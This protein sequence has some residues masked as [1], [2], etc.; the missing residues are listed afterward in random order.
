[1]LQFSAPQIAG[2]T[3]AF[4]AL[5]LVILLGL[6]E[7][8]YQQRVEAYVKINPC[9]AYDVVRYTHLECEAMPHEY[10]R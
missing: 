3:V 5:M 2:I 8:M 7:A 4:T 9:W 10:T 6:A 1:M